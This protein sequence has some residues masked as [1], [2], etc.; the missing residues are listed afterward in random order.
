M[1]N[2][3]SRYWL[4]FRKSKFKSAFKEKWGDAADGHEEEK[5]AWEEDE[6]SEVMKGLTWFPVD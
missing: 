1:G 2:I 5:S 6:T 3:W 4:T